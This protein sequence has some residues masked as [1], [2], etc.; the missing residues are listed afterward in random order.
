MQL[1]CWLQRRRVPK[2]VRGKLSRKLPDMRGMSYWPIPHW[3]HRNHNRE[4]FGMFYMPH[5]PVPKRVRRIVGGLVRCVQIGNVQ[6][7]VRV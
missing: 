3:L 6:N 4:M 2:R 7:V 5:R 1:V